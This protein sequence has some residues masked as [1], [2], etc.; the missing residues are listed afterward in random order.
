MTYSPYS[1]YLVQFIVAVGFNSVCKVYSD[2]TAIKFVY[3]ENSALWTSHY[4]IITLIEASV[5]FNFWRWLI[6]FVAV[7]FVIMLVQFHDADT[8]YNNH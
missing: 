7:E 3:H 2:G 4:G 1:P 6:V 8:Y 5:K